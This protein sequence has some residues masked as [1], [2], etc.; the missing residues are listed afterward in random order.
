M[1]S[2]ETPPRAWG[3][4]DGVLSDTLAAR[5]TPTCVGKTPLIRSSRI[6][7]GKHPHVRG[8][9]EPLR[10][11]FVPCSE[12]PPRAWGRRQ[13]R[14]EQRRSAGNTPTCVGKTGIRHGRSFATW[15]HPH[16]RGEDV[17]V[18]AV[19]RPSTETPPRAWGRPT[20]VRSSIGASG[21]T[22]TCVGKTYARTRRRPAI[23]KHPH[24]RGEDF[25]IVCLLLF[26]LET[27]P[28]A[29]GRPFL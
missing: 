21:N 17:A 14:A 1:P 15:K 27:P 4:R 3:R 6:P 26:H 11:V 9:D 18:M 10:N 29:W 28:R 7:I 19:I 12:T 25:H 22:P 24:V 5:N 13:K 16:V 20:L 2:V 8:E 23:Q